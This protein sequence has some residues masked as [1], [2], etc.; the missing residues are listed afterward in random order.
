MSL[1]SLLENADPLVPQFQV[2]KAK[3]LPVK[4]EQSQEPKPPVKDEK[5]TGLSGRTRLRKRKT[6]DPRDN[7]TVFVGNIPS[8]C[9][10]KHIK[11]LF[12]EYSVEKV[13]LRS[14]RV[15]QDVS[16]PTRVAKR[17]Q[18]LAEGSTFNAYV[19]LSTQAEAERSLS[20]N[21]AFLKGRHI[22]VDKLS[23]GVEDK[24]QHCQKSVFVGNLPFT[25]DEEELRQSFSGC[26]EVESVRIVRDTKTGIGKGFGFVSFT[27]KSGVMFATK[28]NKKL[29]LNDRKLRVFRAQDEQTLKQQRQTKFAGLQANKQSRAKKKPRH[30]DLERNNFKIETTKPKIQ[31]HRGRV[32][33]K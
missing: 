22:R 1:C 14:L 25:A 7:R 10:R 19:I 9:S 11:Q 29:T 4:V 23:K 5:Q 21:G 18:K 32:A 28:Q 13:R 8:T 33:M 2:V 30:R 12:K 15:T 31:K 17:T 6:R 20:L 24:A 3:H 16:L 26:G 27:D